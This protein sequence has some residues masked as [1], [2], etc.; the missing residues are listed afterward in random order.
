MYLLAFSLPQTTNYLVAAL[1]SHS[2]L[3][4]GALL[5]NAAAA[6]ALWQWQ[7]RKL[8][9]HCWS[10]QPLACW[11][12]PQ[13]LLPPS[14]STHAAAVA[15]AT[16]DLGEGRMSRQVAKGPPLLPV[17]K[18]KG[19]NGRGGDGPQQ[20]GS[21]GV[22]P[23]GGKQRGRGGPTK[24]EVSSSGYDI[25][26]AGGEASATSM[27]PTPPIMHHPV[28]ICVRKNTAPPPH[29]LNPV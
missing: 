22:G 20:N 26:E 16:E 12:N 5:G 9:S 7:A 15:A 2:L 25:T 21:G 24:H 3:G 4:L 10:L 29:S 6:G 14:A 8:L 27:C 18:G 28:L 1:S 13:G 19:K 23:A 17:W 11:D